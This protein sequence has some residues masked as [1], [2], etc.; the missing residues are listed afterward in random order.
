MIHYNNQLKYKTLYKM[1]KDLTEA[2]SLRNLDF[3]RGMI[4]GWCCARYPIEWS[5]QELERYERVV[6]KIVKVKEKELK[7]HIIY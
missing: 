7:E 3:Q 2:Y 6:K 5:S 4:M 1:L